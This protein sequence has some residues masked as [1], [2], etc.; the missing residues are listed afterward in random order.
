[1]RMPSHLRKFSQGYSL[2]RWVDHR[3]PIEEIFPCLH[4]LAA[5]LDHKKFRNAGASEKILVSLAAN[6]L[7]EEASLE[8]YVFG[9]EPPVSFHDLSKEGAMV[10]VCEAAAIL[11]VR[12]YR[13]AIEKGTWSPHT[14]EG[15]Q[16]EQ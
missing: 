13:T 4:V 6:L 5:Q 16:G 9:L 2:E 3:C 12:R 14:P 10:P 11:V 15:E 1:M 8:D 7:D